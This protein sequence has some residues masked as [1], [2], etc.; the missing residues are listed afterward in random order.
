MPRVPDTTLASLNN[1]MDLLRL[2]AADLVNILYGTRETVPNLWVAVVPI[3][4]TVN[5]GPE[6]AV[7]AGRR[8]RRQP[9]R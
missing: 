5:L 4:T 6:P 9:H 2:A 8:Q 1:N 3:A 7:L